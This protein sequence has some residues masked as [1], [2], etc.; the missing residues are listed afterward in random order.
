[1]RLEN[2]PILDAAEHFLMVPDFLHWMLSGEISNEATNA[3]TTNCSVPMDGKWSE[4]ITSALKLPHKIF[5]PPVQPGHRLG[6]I[7]PDYRNE[8][9]SQ[10]CK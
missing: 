5:S 6:P 9:V 4:R 8:L 7:L 1:M 3:S 10:A 2:S